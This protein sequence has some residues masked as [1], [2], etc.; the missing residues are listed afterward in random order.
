[1]EAF[2][3]QAGDVAPSRTLPPAKIDIARL[4]V[5]GEETGAMKTLGPPPFPVDMLA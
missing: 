4:R 2:Y 5:A 3:R 1:M